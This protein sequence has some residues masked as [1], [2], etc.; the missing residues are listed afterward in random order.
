MQAVHQPRMEVVSTT[1]MDVV[2]T[3]N[4]N[5]HMNMN[6]HTQPPTERGI[7]SDSAG[8]SAGGSSHKISGSLTPKSVGF[9][10]N[11]EPPLAI[12]ES[13]SFERVFAQVGIPV[14]AAKAW[15]HRAVRGVRA[16]MTETEGRGTGTTTTTT[17]INTDNLDLLLTNVVVGMGGGSPHI[18]MYLEP[19][20]TSR[21]T[22]T[23][24]AMSTSTTT[25]AGL[26][27]LLLPPDAG[28][29]D[30]G[31]AIELLV[32]PVVTPTAFFSRW[33][34]RKSLHVRRPSHAQHFTSL[35]VGAPEIKHVLEALRVRGKLAR[36]AR[37]HRNTV[38]ISGRGPLPA[39]A[40]SPATDAAGGNAKGD[41]ART[42]RVP[43]EQNITVE[44]FLAIPDRDG[45]SVVATLTEVLSDSSSSSSSSSSLTGVA[46]RLRSLV[47]DF[48]RIF[49]TPPGVN[50]Y[51]SA[52]NDK[53]LPP[54]TDRYDVFVLQLWGTKT[55]KTC[56]P[57]PTIPSADVGRASQLTDAELAELHEVQ[58]SATQGCSTHR[59]RQN[60]VCTEFEMAAGDTLYMPKGVIHA[61]VT[62]E[63]STA[64]LTISI[65]TGAFTWAALFTH[66]VKSVADPNRECTA[67]LAAANAVG[68][69]PRRVAG[70]GW[71][72]VLPHL[73]TLVAMC[74]SS[75]DDNK[76]NNNN[77]NNGGG[78]G[79]DG[80]ASS[81]PFAVV[82]QLKKHLDTL[83]VD[84]AMEG[85]LVQEWP[86]AATECGIHRIKQ[87]SRLRTVA[88]A[89]RLVGGLLRRSP[90]VFALDLAAFLRQATLVARRKGNVDGMGGMGGIGG[91]GGGR[92]AHCQGGGRDTPTLLRPPSYPSFLSHTFG[93][94]QLAAAGGQRNDH[95]SENGHH[96]MSQ[97]RRLFS[98]AKTCEGSCT[99]CWTH[100]GV[101]QAC[102]HQGK[103]MDC[104]T[105]TACGCD[106][107]GLCGD[108]NCDDCG[109][110]NCD[111][112]DKQT[113][114]APEVC[115]D[116]C[117][118][119][120][121]DADGYL[122]QCPLCPSRMWGADG[123]KCQMCS[124]DHYC[125][126]GNAR[127][128]CTAG[129]I[130]PSGSSKTGD[131]ILCA[132]GTYADR[133][134]VGCSDVPALAGGAWKSSTGHTCAN[135]VTNKW[136]TEDGKY[137]T[138]WDPSSY[139][140][141]ARWAVGGLDASSSCCGCGGGQGSCKACGG[142]KMYS[143]AGSSTCSTCP[144]GSHT[145]GGSTN[146]HTHCE[147]C[148]AGSKCDGSSTVTQC[149]KGYYADGSSC[150]KC[151]DD[152]KYS[153]AGAATCSTCP[154]GSQTSGGDSNT[155][156]VCTVCGGGFQCDG[157][158]TSSK[159][160]AGKYRSFS[161]PNTCQDCGD[162]KKYVGEETLSITRVHTF[163]VENYVQ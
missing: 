81:L 138:G 121:C 136:C 86:L 1:D 59:H 47:A 73:P 6:T 129:S 153:A 146:T 34:R 83:L 43:F 4:T 48:T 79:N 50:L 93:R 163:S 80:C 156:Q 120:E 33:F 90:Q 51:L 109:A 135:Y 102:N 124:R 55:W 116:T 152:K 149:G 132:A 87:P 158:S 106:L 13:A 27:G 18:T 21:S 84:T 8:D 19:R 56:L 74:A 15:V 162:D 108:N 42:Q 92:R 151:N 58:I 110:W 16:K 53:V 17:T 104:D 139:Y 37:R 24:A 127:T 38:L 7:A 134:R 145:K 98:S 60:M 131:C 41:A 122:C 54:H 128:A 126:G 143:A 99:A 32:S 78:G 39:Q 137:G 5:T 147:A 82:E 46:P 30:E 101:L 148:P 71:R 9:N 114:C 36:G 72:G 100:G 28:M 44:E 70:V 95:M 63:V 65:P 144:T 12:L 159:C 22:A 64:H 141:F 25:G 142:D 160:P 29:K 140:N 23:T 113:A 10:F 118:N 96:Y 66:L 62:G 111:S 115:D 52:A 103:V 77:N 49:G 3:A 67:T 61:A 91:M 107:N 125:V 133:T 88:A 75:N 112:C 11:Y 14:D 150:L 130:A 89:R 69:L 20:A 40:L 155:R 26:A 57:A 105:T 68:N 117:G 123:T 31:G 119:N 161:M 76:N 45:D 35:L 157:S 85:Q 2:A 94:R 97:R 154:A